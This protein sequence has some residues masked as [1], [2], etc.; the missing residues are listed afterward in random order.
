VDSPL[1]IEEQLYLSELKEGRKRPHI[2][3]VS[4]TTA[5]RFHFSRTTSFG[6]HLSSRRAFECL[7]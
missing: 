2:I 1:K 5:G 4:Y 3:A 6:F 7:K